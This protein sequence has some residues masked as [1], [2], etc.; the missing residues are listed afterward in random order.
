[1]HE[2]TSIRGYIIACEHMANILR[3][4][5][6]SWHDVCRQAKV[7]AGRIRR[8]FFPE[9]ILGVARG[10]LIPARLMA[11][12]LDVST[13]LT[14]GVAF[15][16]DIG[17]T[18]KQPRITQALPSGTLGR[19]V[20][21]VDDVADTGKSL[22]AVV[23]ELRK[24]DLDIRTATLYRK[25]WAEFNPDFF[26]EETDAWIIFPWEHRETAR[27][28]IHG[29]VSEGKSLKEAEEQLVSAGMGRRRAHRLV[30]QVT[31]EASSP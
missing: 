14:V 3:F 25:P 30:R 13:L 19:R 7:L 17:R 5:M 22:E 24:H 28:I 10:G 18:E 1:M 6:P 26:A 31:E 27:K 15:Y 29:I 4:V 2:T 12:F 16:A 21:V 9:V 8:S 11:D 23:T 20:L